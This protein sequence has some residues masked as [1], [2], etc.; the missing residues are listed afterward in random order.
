MTAI[1]GV[2]FSIPVQRPAAIAPE[3]ASARQNQQQTN[4]E[5]LTE[6]EEKTVRELKQRD[7]EVRAH[8]QA[9]KSVGGPYAGAV[10]FDT[11][12]GPDGREYAVGGEVQIDASAVRGNPEETIRKME[13]VI[14]AALAPAEPSPQDVQVA[15]Q[16]QQTKL[17]AQAELRQERA[18]EAAERRGEGGQQNGL[19][20]AL[21]AFSD[22]E[23]TTRQTTEDITG[24]LLDIA[25]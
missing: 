14:R 15:A 4:A 8:E 1:S 10:S 3:Q 9:H 18:E 12:T 19:L 16:A 7:I 5:G 22:A 17:Q 21:Q 11:V 6:A 20:A 25:V 13:I 24:I 2:Q 23:K